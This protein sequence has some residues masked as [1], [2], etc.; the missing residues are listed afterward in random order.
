MPTR[1]VPVWSLLLAAAIAQ[2]PPGYKTWENK[3]QRV[4]FFYPVAYAEMPLPPTE[5]VTVAKFV[6]K[7]KP[8]DLDLDDATFD[9]LKPQLEVFHFALAAPTTGAPA[10]GDATTGG[11]AAGGDGGHGERGAEPGGAPSTLREAME[12]KSRVRSWSEFV[13]RFGRWRLD[14]EP[15]KPGHFQLTYTGEWA[16]RGVPP[17]VGFLVRREDGG[18][19]HG[20]YG[21]GPGAYRKQ[22]QTQVTK[23]GGSLA[24]AAEESGDA[25]EA[26]IER[27]YAS[28]KYHAV[29]LRK[30][31]RAEL[32]KGWKALDTEHYLIVHHS[33]NEG[34]VKRIAR[35][36]EAMRAL[37]MQLFPPT[38]AMDRL[39]IVRVC[40]TKEEYHQYGG[41]PASGGYWHP[42][43]EELVFYDYSYTMKTLD[44]DERKRIGKVLT[45]DDS[46]LVLYHEAFHQ[47][48]HYAVGEFSPHD[49]FNEGF[50]DYFSGAQIGDT[51]G[52]VL[53]IEP[54]PWRIH[55]AKDMCEFGVGFIS[56]REILEAE[57]AVFYNPARIRFFYAGAWSFLYFLQTAKE[58]AAHAAWSKLLPTYF[59]AMKEAYAAELAKAGAQPSLE[60]KAIA[61]FGARKAALKQ[62]LA[63][64]DVAELERAWK[65]WV[66]D[67]KD[68]WPSKRP[69]RPK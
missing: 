69:K 64:I 67:M 40:R 19:I 13:Q 59:T 30:K 53:R 34:L 15:K 49:W 63:G 5:Q 56:L 46:L 18:A 23:M 61:G 3:L 52:R 26:A 4:T 8:H 12:A 16:R 68:P 31:A 33:K 62:A 47:Y 11:A 37:Y 65:K 10:A 6:L 2:A 44:D 29:E 50:G 21:F 1:H 55:T 25:A 36:I 41:P 14:E 54:S 42:G 9:A 58:V 22:L 24:L 32:A 17:P 38:G 45:D 39:A 35:D 43:N 51:T 28:G 27:L 20:V 48:I 57:R 60:Q 66:V 7:A